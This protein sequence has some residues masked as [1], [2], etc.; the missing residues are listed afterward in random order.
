MNASMLPL[1][2]AS[3]CAIS[4]DLISEAGSEACSAA[5]QKIAVNRIQQMLT[6]VCN[7]TDLL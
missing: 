5:A 7:D 6:V 1:F 2:H 4:T 3:C